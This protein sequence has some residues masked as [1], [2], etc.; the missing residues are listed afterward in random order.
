MIVN[1]VVGLRKL[2]KVLDV[3]NVLTTVVEKAGRKS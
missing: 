3:P 1:N 2:A